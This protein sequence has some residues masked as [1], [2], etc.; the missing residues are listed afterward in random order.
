MFR[1]P[2]KRLL[3]APE[4]GKNPGT[5]RRRG[6]PMKTPQLALLACLLSLASLPAS[7]KEI[8]DIPELGAH[9]QIFLVEKNVN[10][11]NVAV[12]YTRLDAQCRFVPDAENR[13]EPV[14]DFYWRM[15][16]SSYKPMNSF[17]KDEFHRR[18]SFAGGDASHFELDANDLKEVK[19]D[20]GAN[21]RVTVA[22]FRAG[23]GCDVQAF[24][25]LGPS[26]GHARIRIDSIYGEGRSFP[27]K[28][29]SVTLKGEVVDQ[30]GKGTGK[31]VA[32]KY[33]AE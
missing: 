1:P 11:E 28:V 31:M 15:N 25:T 27:P 12:V 5:E 18:M 7:A 29:Y 10:P 3:R 19:H 8:T 4:G 26:D 24:I 13:D 30:N 33:S 14:F 6:I 22:A 32:R 9:Q 2:K 20:L 17:F 23:A 21:P 16:R